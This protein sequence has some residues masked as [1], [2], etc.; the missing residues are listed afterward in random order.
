MQLE[1]RSRQGRHRHPELRYSG[2][3]FHTGN[4][5]SKFL[6]ARPLHTFLQAT[7]TKSSTKGKRFGLLFYYPDCILFLE[8]LMLLYWLSCPAPEF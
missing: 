3:L 6:G 2:C 5:S 8:L 7:E 1:S 4:F